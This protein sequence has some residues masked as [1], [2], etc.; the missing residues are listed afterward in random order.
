MIADQFLH[1]LERCGSELADVAALGEDEIDD[2][3]L[4]VKHVVIKPRGK[5]AVRTAAVRRSDQSAPT[6]SDYSTP[7]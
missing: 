5:H 2:D 3:D 4:L 7:G 1:T 6:Y